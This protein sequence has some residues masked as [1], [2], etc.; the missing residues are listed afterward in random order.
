MSSGQYGFD[1]ENHTYT[2][3]KDGAVYFWDRIKNAWFPKVRNMMVIL[4]SLLFQSL[5]F[6]IAFAGR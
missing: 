6:N 3:P 2:D 5:I 1:G 4:F